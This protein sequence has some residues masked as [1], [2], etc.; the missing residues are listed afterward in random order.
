MRGEIVSK[1]ADIPAPDWDACLP[2]EVENH[3]YYVACEGLSDLRFK[4]GAVRVFNGNSTLAVAPFICIDYRLHTSLK[5]VARA[6]TDRLI[7]LTPKLLTLRALALGSPFA[8]RCHLGVAAGLSAEDRQMAVTLLMQTL[9]VHG[10]S[11]G[12]GLVGIKDLAA[13]DEAVHA[14]SLRQL[15]F[16]RMASLPVAITDLPYQTLDNYLASLSA[17]LREHMRRRNRRR[18]AVRFELRE[19]ILGLEAEIH[20]LYCS[21]QAQSSEDYGDMEHLPPDYFGAVQRA[22]PG[23]ALF[24]LYW[25]GPTLVAFNLLLIEKN[26]VIDKYLGMKYPMAREHNLYYL[27]WMDAVNYCISHNIGCLQDGQ[28]AYREKLRLGA[29][30][31]PSGIWFKHKNPFINF[32]LRKFSPFLAFD[33]ADPVLRGLPRE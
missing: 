4:M 22:L 3:A 23:R 8:E 15:G 33:R 14:S 20:A 29:R 30:L 10:Q 2:D 32:L 13:P 7:R 11:V 26:R 31:V 12:A 19:N 6:I 18:A 21:T 1:I 25:V 16:A 5:G 24:A 17:K 9:T 27:R 28:T